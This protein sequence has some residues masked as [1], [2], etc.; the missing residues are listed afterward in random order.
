[1]VNASF[2]TIN[3]IVE[4]VLRK[5]NAKLKNLQKQKDS[6]F[7]LDNCY[8]SNNSSC[9]KQKTAI[10]PQVNPKRFQNQGKDQKTKIFPIFSR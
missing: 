1:M 10:A 4:L 2:H 3:A 6:I 7:L 8:I 9:K 5:R